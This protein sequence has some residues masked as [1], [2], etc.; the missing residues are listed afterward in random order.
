MTPLISLL[1]SL[2]LTQTHSFSLISDKKD[3]P[4]SSPELYQTPRARININRAT[5]EELQ[6]LPGIGPATAQRIV[7]YRKKNPPFRKVDDLLII[8]GISKTKLEKLREHVKVE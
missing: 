5:P 7:D 6:A 3:P 4:K 8:R 2:L 1:L